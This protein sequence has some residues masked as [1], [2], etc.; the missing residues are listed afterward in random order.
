MDLLAAMS[1]HHRRRDEHEHG[2][3]LEEEPIQ[4]VLPKRRQCLM[5]QTAFESAWSG[6]R[7]CPKCKGKSVWR[8]G[9]R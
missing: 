1:D 3:L 7:I 2:E 9:F 5:C 6:E 4:T 8:E